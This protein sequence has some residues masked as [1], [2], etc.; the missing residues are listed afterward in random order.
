MPDY[1]KLAKGLN[2]ILKGGE[3]V[4]PAA[5]AAR[6]FSPRLLESTTSKMMDDLLATNPKLTPEEAFKKASTQAE[7][8]LTWEREQKPALVKQYGPLARASY[9]KS[10][11]QKMQNTPEVVQERIRKANEFLDQPTEPW[12]P[13]RPELQAF[14][15]SAIKDARSNAC[16]SGRGG[17]QGS[18]G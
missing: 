14:D 3:E 1:P 13:P 18:V 8:K 12:T 5:K 6:G 10:N 16:N 2:A 7:K 17:V 9:A 15:R 4:A 11:P